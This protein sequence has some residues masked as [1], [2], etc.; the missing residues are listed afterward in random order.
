MTGA[1]EKVG[2]LKF[3]EKKQGGGHTDRK[4]FMRE[5]KIL[6]T[7][8]GEKRG[9]GLDNSAHLMMRK[10]TGTKVAQETR[11]RSQSYAA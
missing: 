9:R 6:P 4:S 3:E 7:R 11:G 5:Q 2:I 10:E 1:Q 8:E